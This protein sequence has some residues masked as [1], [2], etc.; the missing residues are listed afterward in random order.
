MDKKCCFHPAHICPASIF[1]IIVCTSW[2]VFKVI[3][4]KEAV[5]RTALKRGCAHSTDLCVWHTHSHT[6]Y[7]N[8]QKYRSP[9]YA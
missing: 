3:Y 9:H 8:P 1:I 2:F 5:K 4:C 7:S 6:T